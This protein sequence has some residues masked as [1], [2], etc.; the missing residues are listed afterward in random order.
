[1]ATTGAQLLPNGAVKTMCKELLPQTFILTPNVPEAQLMLQEAGQPPVEI[2][3]LASLKQLAAAVHRLGVKHVLLKG[4]HLPL[5]SDYE[6]AKSEVDKKIVVNIL[7]GDD[8]EE[9]IECPFQTSKNTH[10]TGCS[11]ACTLRNPLMWLLLINSDMIIAALAC[12]LAQ[13]HDVVSA[14]RAAC[15]Y[16]DAGIRASIDL[17][18]GSGPINHFH[19]LQ[20]LPFTSYAFQHKDSHAFVVLMSTQRLL[21][22]LSARSERRQTGVA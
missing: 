13:G 16:V 7:L 1:M 17:G 18:K 15:R 4:G 5:S 14:T 12:D 2:Q 11:L 3:D 6:V 22:R 9:V 20:M 21:C 19:S 8:I 10:G